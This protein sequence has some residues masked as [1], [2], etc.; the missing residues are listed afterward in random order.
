MDTSDVYYDGGKLPPAEYDYNTPSCRYSCD[1]EQVRVHHLPSYPSVDPRSSRTLLPS[2]LPNCQ[3]SNPIQAHT[4]QGQDYLTSHCRVP[5]DYPGDSPV[6]E[7]ESAGDMSF[8]WMRRSRFQSYQ[9]L[10]GAFYQNAEELKRNRTAYSRAQ[11]LEL[12]KEF[13]FNQYISRPR[14]YE[15]ATT[16]N[17]TE[18]HVKIWFQNRRMK[19]KKEQTK[20]RKSPCGPQEPEAFKKPI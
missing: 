3:F 2:E 13:L 4:H 7:G 12:E 15:L 10:P 14:R 17:L 18:R 16:L 5:H 11:L 9:S 19:W 8:P 20:T 6:V 1:I